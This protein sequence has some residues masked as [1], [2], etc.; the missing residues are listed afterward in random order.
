MVQIANFD[1]INAIGKYYPIIVSF[2][3]YFSHG[4][5][6]CGVQMN[7]NTT[8]HEKNTI[9]IHPTLAFFRLKNAILPL[10]VYL[11]VS[12]LQNL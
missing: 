9:L 12:I 3:Y 7:H 1:N 4:K 2:I 6:D 5:V 10:I 11:S 8:F